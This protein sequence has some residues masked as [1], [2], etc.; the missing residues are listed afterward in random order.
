MALIR[1]KKGLFMTVLVLILF[2]LI[3]SELISFALLDINYNNLDQS[4]AVGSSSVNYGKVFG[5]S[6]TQFANASLGTALK[7]LAN[8]EFNSSLRGNNLISNTSQYL[9]YLMTNGMLPNVAAGTIP[10][11]FLSKSM[12]NFTLAS[13]NAVIANSLQLGG[14]AVKVNE[15]APSIYQSSPYSLSVG[16]IENVAL[17][18]TSGRFTYQIPINATISLNNTPD[19]FYYQQGIARTIKLASISNLTSLIGNM[20]ASNGNFLA[21]AYGPI[22]NVPTGSGGLTC[23]NLATMISANM[24]AFSFAPYN[25]MLILATSN[26]IGIT[27]GASSSQCADQYGGLIT[28]SVNSVALPP[29]IPWLAYSSSTSLLGNLKNGQQVLIVGNTLSTYNIQNLISA[30][31]RGYYFASSSAPSYLD[32][33]QGS[34]TKQNQNGIFALPTYASQTG[35]FNGVSSYVPVGANSLPAGSAARSEFAWIYPT[36]GSRYSVI[37][38]YGT[39]PAGNND[40]VFYINTAGD[41]AFDGWGNHDWSTLYPSLNSWHLV[42]YTYSAGSSQITFYM[43]GQTNTNSLQSGALNT[44]IPASDPANIG[45]AKA[46][47]LWFQGSIAN[48]QAYA[49]ALTSSQASQL[50]QEGITG[51]PIAGANMVGWWP[52]SGNGNDYS[53]QANN[54]IP[55]NVVYTLAANYVRD[56]IIPPVGTTTLSPIPGLLNCNSNSQCSNTAL[57][58]LYLGYN[59]VITTQSYQ[60]VGGF[61]GLTDNSYIAVSNP[62]NS[63]NIVGKMTISAWIYP[64]S[65]TAENNG[66]IYEQESCNAQYELFLEAQ[67]LKLRFVGQTSDTTYPLNGLNTWYH[68]VGTYDGSNGNLY[69]NGTLVKSL[70]QAAPTASFPNGPGYIGQLTGG[71]ANYDFIGNIANVQVYGTALSSTQVKQLYNE[72]I[73]GLPIP[74]NALAGWWPLNGNPNDYSGYSNNGAITNVYFPYFSGTYNSPGLSTVSTAANEWQTIGIPRSGG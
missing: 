25:Q 49:Q 67:Y 19:L 59:P 29:A 8:Y 24:P 53:G 4:I 54:G 5:A 30:A 46:Q 43:D 32:Y 50:Y 66:A 26:A 33:A 34:I 72:G 44:V 16:Y 13:Y 64:T 2:L 20:N 27:Q 55:V 21:T 38:E 74:T 31:G 6:A 3:L 10:A 17:N 51:L 58:H 7:T 28:Y 1:S 63:L 68:V 12:G 45:E 52:L 41:L 65:V 39:A 57:A 73:Q 9:S 40:A 47:G 14:I 60:Q 22:Y 15:T 48:V 18:S 42:G 37:F 35:S 71:C 36:A 70:S 23:A 69:I 61:N 11:N 56:A 62:S